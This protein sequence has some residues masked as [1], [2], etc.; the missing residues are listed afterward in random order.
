MERLKQ[1]ITETVRGVLNEYAGVFYGA[2]EL[3]K[4]ILSQLRRVGW[5]KNPPEKKVL[6]IPVWWA[7]AYKIYATVEK[8][9]KVRAYY[10]LYTMS[11]NCM[12][13]ISISSSVISEPDET[14]IPTI[15]HELTHAYEDCQRFRNGSKLLYDIASD[16]GHQKYW[17]YNLNTDSDEKDEYLDDVFTFTNLS[18]SFEKNARAA[19]LLPL[20]MNSK[21]EFKTVDDAILFLDETG[22]FKKLRFLKGFTEDILHE[23]SKE[24]QQIWLDAFS[25][26]T[27]LKFRSYEHLKKYC[28]QVYMKHEKQVNDAMRKAINYYFQKKNGNTA[29]RIDNM[30]NNGG[31]F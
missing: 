15:V 13:V 25:K 3:A 8:S 16:R 30:I 2:E 29:S 19:T 26:I 23:V 7:P 20:L 27:N 24:E 11:K 10:N 14:L 1:I 21:K 31:R 4:E 9:L 18:S 12:P 22:P 6:P 5:D 28:R 17:T